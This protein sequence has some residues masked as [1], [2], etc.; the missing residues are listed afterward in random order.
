MLVDYAVT[1]MGFFDDYSDATPRAKTMGGNG[2]TTFILHGA[3]C[4]TFRQTNIVKA[5][6]IAEAS[7]KS[8]YS[9]LGF[10]VIK[11]FTKSPNS[12]EAR[13]RFNYESGKSKALQKKI[14]LQCHQTIPRRVTIIHCNII[15]FNENINVFKYL[16]E[17]PPSDDWV[18]YVN[19]T[20]FMTCQDK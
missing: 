7:L 15:D 14:G 12:E 5:I 3:Q 10:K 19:Q 8:F 18:P 13:K 20:W 4:I 6:L 9:G 17:V 2:I 1:D 16:N 11:D